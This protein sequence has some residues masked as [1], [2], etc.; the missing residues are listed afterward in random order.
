MLQCRML[1]FRFLAGFR[2][3]GERLTYVDGI[4]DD[5]RFTHEVRIRTVEEKTNQFK[6]LSLR[7]F[8]QKRTRIVD[9][10]PIDIARHY[11][12]HTVEQDSSTPRIEVEGI[13]NS[14]TNP[15]SIPQ[16]QSLR[17]VDSTGETNQ[18]KE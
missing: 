14:H 6:V 2:K 12:S 1:S 9:R 15:L 10:Y 13:P 18:Y 16:N 8:R 17:S 4:G 5:P 7:A 3:S 11:D